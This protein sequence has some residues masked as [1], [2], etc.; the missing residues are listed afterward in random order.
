MKVKEFM[1]LFEG[2]L[3]W[4]RLTVLVYNESGGDTVHDKYIGFERGADMEIKSIS[5]PRKGE[6]VLNV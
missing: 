5:Q 1:A 3:N 2:G 4:N 6:I